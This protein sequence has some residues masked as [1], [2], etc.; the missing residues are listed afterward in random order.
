M[1]GTI[2]KHRPVQHSMTRGDQIGQVG[3]VPADSGIG[4]HEDE[5]PKDL[6]DSTFED[7]ND[8]SIW[9]YCKH[10]FTT[11]QR[12]RGVQLRLTEQV[13]KRPLHQTYA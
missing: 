8:P 1:K 3:V 9:G 6:V 4:T 2:G 5:D 12:G 10:G 13:H 11:S 7:C